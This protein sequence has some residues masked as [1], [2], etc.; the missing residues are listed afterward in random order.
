MPLRTIGWQYLTRIALTLVICGGTVSSAVRAQDT[1]HLPTISDYF[2]RD[3]VAVYSKYNAAYSKHDFKVVQS[4]LAPDFAFIDH[5]KAIAHQKSVAL[6][7]GM[8][9]FDK[10]VPA[11]SDDPAYKTSVTLY[12]VFKKADQATVLLT[13]NIVFEPMKIHGQTEN[14]AATFYWKQT[15]TKTARGWQLLKISALGKKPVSGMY[16]ITLHD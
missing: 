12:K 15:W 5:G 8:E 13:Q 2:P 10:P 4:L 11:P 16:S 14:S 9:E 7:N 3:I 6:M 1:D